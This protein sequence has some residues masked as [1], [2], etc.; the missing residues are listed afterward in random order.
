MSKIGIGDLVLLTKWTSFL[1]LADGGW[2][3]FDYKAD[4]KDVAVAL[5]L[6]RAPRDSEEPIDGTARLNAIGWFGLDKIGEVVAKIDA[7]IAE[8][9]ATNDHEEGLIASGM[10][11]ALDIIEKELGLVRK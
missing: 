1:S 11:E 8:C 6:G 4:K 9:E 10:K 7:R 2:A 5:F 3:T